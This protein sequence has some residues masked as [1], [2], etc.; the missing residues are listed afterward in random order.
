M[1]VHRFYTGPELKL[2]NDFWL[3]DQALLWQWNKVLRFHQGQQVILFDGEKTER[4]YKIS[5][6]DKTEAHLELV[7]EMQ[8]KLAKRHVYLFWGLLKKNNNDF[9]LQKGTEL[10]VSTFVPLLG[11]RTVATNFNHERAKKIIIEASEQCGRMV[12]PIVREPMHL[13]TAL[14][15]YAKKARLLVCQQGSENKPQLKS[16]QG[17]G[18]LIGPE[19]GWSDGEKQLFEEN[20][21]EHL[22]I[23]DL[24]LRA[25][26]AAIV[27]AAKL[28]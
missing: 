17:V 1:R 20:K 2:K 8:P 23:S 3:H 22:H 14:D 11:E 27:A 13:Q 4:L 5:R 24:T 21:L 18:V 7:A 16:G 12:L 10:G 26:T 9:V 25:E 6:L 28:L 19:G 15:E